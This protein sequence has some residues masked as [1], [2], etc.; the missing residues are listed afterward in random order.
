M[1][2]LAKHGKTIPDIPCN[3]FDMDRCK[4]PIGL[5]RLTAHEKQYQVDCK[6]RKFCV[7][8]ES[9]SEPYSGLKKKQGA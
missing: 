6:E 5:A 9:A 7:C 4:S 8:N 2:K 3:N 1:L